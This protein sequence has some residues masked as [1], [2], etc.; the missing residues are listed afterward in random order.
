V[1]A[2]RRFGTEN[3]FTETTL[4]LV[5]TTSNVTEITKE[6]HKIIRKSFRKLGSSGQI[7][8]PMP[9][10]QLKS[11]GNCVFIV[12]APTLWN[13]LLTDIRNGSS[14]ENLKSILKS[15]HGFFHR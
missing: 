12:A 4:Y 7:L 15:I 10:S 3:L 1:S 6:N 5:Q 8:V 11:Y 9:V 13:W 14:L 2:K